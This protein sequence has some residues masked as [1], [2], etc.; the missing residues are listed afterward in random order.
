MSEEQK[1]L[2][3]YID[4]DTLNKEYVSPLVKILVSYIK[5]SF[6]FKSEILTPIHLGRAV[7]N[8]KSK[9]GVQSDENL[10][11][12]HENCEFSDNF[13]GGLSQYNRRIGFLTGTYWAW[14]NYN[15]LGNPE[16]FGS[17]G[18]RR[19]LKPDF[20]KDLNKY[21]LIV[22]KIKDFKIETI[23]DQFI[24]YHGKQLYD[25]VIGVF[26]KIYPGEYKYLDTYLNLTSGYFDEIYVMH[27]DIFFEFCNWIFPL[28]FE[29]LKIPQ[30]TDS[31]DSRD[32][33][34]IM[35]RLTGYFLYRL[36]LRNDINYKQEG[37]VITEEMKLNKQHITKDLFAKLRKGIK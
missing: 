24:N 26:S 4:Y 17:F 18:Y 36:T 23:K 30:R 31:K 11:W 14:K 34:F 33:A 22:P 32:I 16:Y 8:I 15:L 19:L 3:N 35:E 21:D 12:L 2:D 20:L 13:V 7:E 5:P 10:K 1:L 27:K 29:F 9:D 28:L 6:L 25:H 37:V